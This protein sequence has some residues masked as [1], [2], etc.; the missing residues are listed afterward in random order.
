[1]QQYNKTTKKCLTLIILPKKDI[2]EYNPHWPESPDY[3]YRIVV[4]RGSGS[5]KTNKLLNLIYHEPDIDRIYL[6]TKN[7]YEAKSQL[8]INKRENA[9]LK[10]LNDS[11]V[12]IEYSNDMDDIFKNIVEYNSNEKRKILIVFDGMITDMLSNKK[13]NPIVNELFRDGKVQ[14]N[15]NREAAKLSELLSGKIDDYEFLKQRNI[16]V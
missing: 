2:K 8:L 1:M 10:N 13:L 14:C 4:V 11:K 7:P 9:G 12:F 3:P 5:G 15:I 16:A 6:Y